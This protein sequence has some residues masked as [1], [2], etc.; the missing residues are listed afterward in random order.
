MAIENSQEDRNSGRRLLLAL[1][2]LVIPLGGM[3][4]FIVGANGGGDVMSKFSLFGLLTVPLTPGAMTL[5]GMIL[6]TVAIGI[7]Y[8]AV[9]IASRYETNTS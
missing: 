7:L 4:G 9:E 1:G 5:Y 3:I 8:G 2:G 6:I